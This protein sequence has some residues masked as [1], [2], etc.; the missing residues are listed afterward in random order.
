MLV[1]DGVRDEIELSIIMPCLNEENTVGISVD[2]ALKFIKKNSISGEVIVVDNGSVDKSAQIA[3]GH[4]AKVISEVRRGYGRALRTGF[5]HALG[6]ILIMGDC[7]TTYDFLKLEEMFSLLHNKKCDMVIGNRYAG[8]IEKGAMSR[9]HRYGVRFLSFCGR[10]K[11]GV[12]VYDFHCGIR[13]FTKEAYERLELKT[14]G[15]EFAT[16]LIAEAARKKL[17]IREVPVPLKRCSLK[18]ESKLRTLRDGLRHLK[19]ICNN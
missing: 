1:E 6:E 13:G 16:E 15:M 10:I 18:R 11:F 9:T 4:G 5:E 14:D 12:D 3:A 2:D 17:T 7:D 19:Y 8:G